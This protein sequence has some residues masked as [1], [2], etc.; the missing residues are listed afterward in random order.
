VL[1]A[2]PTTNDVSPL[3]ARRVDLV[4]WCRRLLGKA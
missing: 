3:D 2:L 4:H 1:G